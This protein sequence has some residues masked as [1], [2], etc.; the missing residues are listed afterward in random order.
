MTDLQHNKKTERQCL[1]TRE[2]LAKD[3]MLRFVASPDNKVF[4]DVNHKLPGKGMWVKAEK[5]TLNKALEKNIFTSKQKNINLDGLNVEMI[6]TQ[7]KQHLL[8]FLAMANKAGLV[9]LGQDRIAQGIDKEQVFAVIVAKDCSQNSKKR[10]QSHIKK[11]IPMVEYLTMEE[12]ESIFSGDK[13][14]FIG[15]KSGK[16]VNKFLNQSLIYSKIFD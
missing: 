16:I 1:V 14:G 7:L 2:I 4:F 12:M 10:L 9:I 13:V 3:D 8:G 15:L 5:E 6:G 11:D